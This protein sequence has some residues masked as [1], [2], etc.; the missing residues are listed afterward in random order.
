M[1]QSLRQ[2][3]SDAI[4]YYGEINRRL[5]AAGVDGIGGLLKL[6]DQL[7][8]ALREV[9]GKE[10]EWALGQIKRVLD[11]IIRI[12]SELKRL[13]G[14]VISVT[15]DSPAEEEEERRERVTG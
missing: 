4:R 1:A 10:V 5:S 7:E 8:R 14:I 3:A 12:D 15:G 9:S 11:E 6:H 2:Q 13:Q